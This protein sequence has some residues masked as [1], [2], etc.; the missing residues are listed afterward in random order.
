MKAVEIKRIVIPDQL[1]LKKHFV[2]ENLS[3]WKKAEHG[4][5]CLSYH[6]KHKIGGLQSRLAWAKGKNLSPK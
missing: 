3:Q 6:S 5:M 2:L 4:G 1:G